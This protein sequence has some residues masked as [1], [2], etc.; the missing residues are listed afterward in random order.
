[1]FDGTAVRNNDD[2]AARRE[3]HAAALELGEPADIVGAGAG[4]TDIDGSGTHQVIVVDSAT[5][6]SLSGIEISD[7]NSGHYTTGCTMISM[8]LTCPAETGIFGG[9]IKNLG[10]LTLTDV[11]VTGNHAGDGTQAS[12]LQVC[13]PTCNG[14]EGGSGGSGGAIYNVGT[15][16]VNDSTIDDNTAGGG[17]AGGNGFGPGTSA[18]NGG[19]GGNGGG[20]GSGGAI[21]NDGGTVI[22]TDSTI[23]DNSAGSGAAGGN[24]SAGGSGDNGGS[25]GNGGDGG[26]G[27]GVLSESGGFVTVTGST[28][29]GNHAGFGNATGTPGAGGGAGTA[30]PTGHPGNG[31]AGG[32]LEFD[33]GTADPLTLTDDT[34]EGNAAG[35][36]AQ[37]TIVSHQGVG[38]GLALDGTGALTNLTVA[39]N[40]GYIGGGIYDIPGSSFAEQN[41]IFASNPGSDD[42]GFGNCG[43]YA[44]V[45]RGHNLTYGDDSCPGTLGNPELGPLAS[46]G[47]PTQTMALESG[48]AAVNL[49]PTA[50][51]AE[52]IDQ[53]GVSRPQGGACDAGAYELAPPTLSSANA[54]ATGVISAE[55]APNLTDTKV[56]VAYGPTSHYVSATGTKD[57]GAGNA[58]DAFS[59]ALTDLRP[60]TTYH[61][62]I[63]A[64]NHDGTSTTSDL[65]FKTGE[66]VTLSVA[67]SS[68]SGTHVQAKVVC[69]AWSQPCSGRLELTVRVTTRGG[70]IIAVTAS[71]GEKAGPKHRTR[72]ET[73]GTA[74]FSI[75][76]GAAKIL[77][78]ALN[79]RGRRLLDARHR[80]PAKLTVAGEASVTKAL[81]FSHPP[82]KRR[83]ARV[84]TSSQ[85]D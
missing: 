7:G 55:I 29:S 51:C 71:G 67:H 60:N 28:L 77:T 53:R 37:D 83:H 15:L 82:R 21:Y 17:A 26:D 66:A 81:T 72:L 45:D 70:K 79:V 44:L 35:D 56:A 12:L 62:A 5:T 46:N 63:N 38:G 61:A 9:G 25:S 4:T 49:V 58:A 42:P 24:G 36:T 75:G 40:S 30:G 32:G 14:T 84:T 16:N 19:N 31:G 64:T 76:A 3:V 47:G 59:V 85:G 73:V 78:L 27:G 74:R 50:A 65:T 23:A 80:L 39:D 6:V 43:G 13:L 11:R 52:T 18:G 57:I 22:I 48:S 54:S 1:M 10:T 20:G 34:I 8:F 33:G 41:T 69:A 2:Q 68:F